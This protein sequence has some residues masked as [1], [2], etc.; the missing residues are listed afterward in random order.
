M[1]KK[2][3]WIGFI[4]LPL[5][6]VFSALRTKSYIE[7]SFTSAPAWVHYIGLVL[8]CVLFIALLAVFAAIAKKLPDT[9]LPVFAVVLRVLGIAAIAVVGFYFGAKWLGIMKEAKWISVIC[10]VLRT[11][12]YSGMWLLVT[13]CL[14][15]FFKSR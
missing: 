7:T 14:K 1:V 3:F 5:Y 10:S 11:L 12:L 13:E 15:F 9:A 4:L 2:L 8:E 6:V